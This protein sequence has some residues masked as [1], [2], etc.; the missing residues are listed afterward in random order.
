MSYIVSYVRTPFGRFGGALKD[1]PAMDLG[2]HAI[3]HALLRAGVPAARVDY[4]LM[5]MVVQAGAGQ[6]PSRQATIKAGLPAEVPSDT[7][8]KVCAS[9]LRAA[10]YAD[11]MIRAGEADVVV[12]G[13]ME[14]M[15][16]APYLL[17]GARWGL[18][19]GDGTLVDAVVHDGLWCSFGNCHM[20]VYGSTVAKEYGISREAQDE[21]A[22]RSHMRAAEAQRAGRLA[23]EIEP[24][25]APG[26][27]GSSV[28]V[29][30]DE[31][32]RPD[33]TLEKLA[34]LKPAF[35]PDGTITAGN[36]PGLNDGAAA[37]VVASERAV[38]EL[39]LRPWAR[40]VAHG[41]ASQDPPYLHTVPWLA[42]Q[43][44]LR[45]AGLTKD[46]IA[47][48]EINEAFAAVTLTSAKLGGLDPERINVNGGAVAL[49]HPIGASGARILGTL[50]MELRRRG[51]GYGVAAICSGGGQGEATVVRVDV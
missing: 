33:T 40:I 1:V 10:N 6:I 19:M 39:G 38:A 7:I 11:M 44:A 35:Q 28:R 12:A 29:E 15:S 34:A 18:R 30:H 14:S 42:A 2:A 13:G 25:D 48:W 20:G 36:A 21:W 45:K 26:P 17:P 23:E 43:A 50:V 47:L 16:Q 41:H 32:I 49:G 22:Y 27:K 46:D 8:N 51:G 3:R 31:A 5:G 9:G 4:V 24:V 37:L